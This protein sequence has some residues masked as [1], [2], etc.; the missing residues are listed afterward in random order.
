MLLSNVD[1][2]NVDLKSVDPRNVDLKSV[3]PRNVDLKSVDP[4]NVDPRN[5]DPSNVTFTE[6]G[7][8]QSILVRCAL[9][10]ALRPV[11]SVLYVQYVHYL[12]PIRQSRESLTGMGRST[13]IKNSCDA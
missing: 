6:C 5:V 7:C 4:R 9:S 13:A 3:D 8:T 12:I 1:P 10:K 2:R 11:L